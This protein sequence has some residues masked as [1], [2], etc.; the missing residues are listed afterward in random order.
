MATLNSSDRDHMTCS[1]K[2]INYLILSIK[3]AEP[4]L[5]WRISGRGPAYYSCGFPC[6]PHPSSLSVPIPAT[7]NYIPSL[8]PMQ[9]QKLTV[10]DIRKLMVMCSE[11]GKWRRRM[12][13]DIKPFDYSE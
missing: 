6:H 2:N 12:T 7:G 4:C 1:V 5:R 9:S 11:G 13:Q 8:L 10:V 3:F